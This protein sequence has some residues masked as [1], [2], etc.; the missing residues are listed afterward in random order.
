[1]VKI[2]EELISNAVN[3]SLRKFLTEEQG[4][5]ILVDNESNRLAQIIRKDLKNASV[6]KEVDYVKRSNNFSTVVFDDF[7]LSV[8]Y[9]FYNFQTF[10]AYERHMEEIEFGGSSSFMEHT[11][12]VNFLGI[13]GEIDGKSFFDSIQHELS[14]IYDSKMKGASLITAKRK[15]LYN[16]SVQKMHSKLNGG[17]DKLLGEIV[18]FS[19]AEE[20]TAFVNGMY[21]LI[22]QDIFTQPME[23]LHQSDAYKALKRLEYYNKVLNS[24]LSDADNAEL[25]A[26]IIDFKGR[27][28]DWFKHQLQLTI[29]SFSKRIMR[30]FY[31]A[32][33]KTDVE[34]AK[35]RP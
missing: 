33:Q 21:N 16:L 22:M 12:S 35:W 32:K 5:A 8:H 14:H 1:M 28:I 18:Y 11:L 34:R 9:T 23:I 3:N 7:N 2:N 27:S 31:L 29:H 6:V 10:E 17:F 4:I 30:A 15:D 25:N 24:D 19:F 26:A 20:Q 13:S